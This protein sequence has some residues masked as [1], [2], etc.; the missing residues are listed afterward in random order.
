MEELG[1]VAAVVVVVVVVIARRVLSEVTAIILMYRS[2]PF[3]FHL[4][5]YCSWFLFQ[6]WYFFFSPFFPLLPILLSSDPFFSLVS[7]ISPSSGFL[8]GLHRGKEW[9]FMILTEFG[10][11]GFRFFSHFLSTHF[12]GRSG[13]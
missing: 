13:W 7:L 1:A 8:R 2:Y 9:F 6:P 4:F 11:N 3:F 5:S 10:W 12:L